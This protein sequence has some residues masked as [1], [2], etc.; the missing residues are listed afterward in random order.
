MTKSRLPT[1][2]HQRTTCRACNGTKLQRF[3]SLGPTPLANSFLQ[4]PTEFPDE[5]WFP[6]DLYFCTDCTLVQLLDVIDPEVLFR[7]YIYVT[8]TS[9]TM[10]RH[11]DAY[12]HAVVERYGLT[13]DDLVV[14]IAS[15]D[16]SL[17]KRFQQHGVRTLG[18]EPAANIAQIA[19][20]DGVETVNVFFDSTVATDLR[21]EHGQASVVIANN[22]LAHVDTPQDFLEGC[23][24]LVGD[25]GAVIIETP[26]LRHLIDR[27]EYDTI[28]HEHHCYFSLRTLLRLAEMAGLVGVHVDHEPVH[29]GSLRF[30][31]APREQQADHASDVLEQLAG[32]ADLATPARY[33]AFAVDVVR[34]GRAL[35]ELL[36]QLR[37]EGKTVGGYGAPAKATTLLIASGID[38]DLLPYT[39]DKN[40]LKV[41]KYLPG[42]HIPVLPAGEILARRPDHVLILA[43]NFAEE[44][45]DQQ[46][47]YRELGGRF[48][49]PI[50]WP[51]VV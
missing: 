11:N 42:S 28:Y 18:V 9:D 40:P 23:R 1:I 22:V 38:S 33:Q 43:W 4:S 24:K 39:A 47:A 49:I 19:N 12:A 29:G 46:K 5:L 27:L 50:P 30:H 32:E 26:Y 48:I 25:R 2:H 16:G 45:M 8:G 34:N 20:A 51:T 10:A 37:A 21:R 17:L 41:G 36:V 44:I 7:D 15:N 14:E 35:R 6:L 31:M 3:L 13:V